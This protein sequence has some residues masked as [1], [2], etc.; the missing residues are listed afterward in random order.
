MN[1]AGY[2]T[3]I[4]NAA[5]VGLP[6][7]DW[8]INNSAIVKPLMGEYGPA[9]LALVGLIGIN[10]RFVTTSPVFKPEADEVPKVGGTE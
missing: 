3:V 2:K 6:L 1:L 5:L 8:I 10:L 4:F 7:T 9:I